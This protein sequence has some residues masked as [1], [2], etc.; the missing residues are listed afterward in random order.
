M[1]L[2]HVCVTRERFLSWPEDRRD[3]W[4]GWFESLGLSLDDIAEFCIDEKTTD[5]LVMVYLRDGDGHRYLDD[6]DVASKGVR[7]NVKDLS[8]VPPY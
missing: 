7:I 1:T 4:S 5:V 2:V 6:G 3:K 8:S